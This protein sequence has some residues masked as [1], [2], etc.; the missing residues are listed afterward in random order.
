MYAIIAS[1]L[2]APMILG[3]PFLAHNDIVVD[4]AVGTVIDKK[5]GF[6]LLNPAAPHAPLPPKEKVEIFL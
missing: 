6:D 1:R 2:C 3:L 5:C 4:A